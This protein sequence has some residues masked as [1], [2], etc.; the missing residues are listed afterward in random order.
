MGM[1]LL[2]EH[3]THVHIKNQA[4]QVDHTEPD[5]TIMWRCQ[6]APLREGIVNWR[7]VLADL[8]AVGYDGWLSF[9]DFSTALPTEQK[10]AE[11]LRLKGPSLWQAPW[12][13]GQDR[14]GRP[15]AALGTG[16]RAVSNGVWESSVKVPGHP[17]TT[18]GSCD[19]MNAAL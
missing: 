2:G 16:L 18:L 13:V 17:L 4:W 9:E 1:E 19:R 6:A 10:I 15:R 7:E 3:L 5:G 12:P 11:N 14:Q 8:R